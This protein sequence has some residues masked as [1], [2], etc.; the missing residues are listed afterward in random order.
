MDCGLWVSGGGLL[1]C[2]LLWYD[3]CY[4]VVVCLLCIREEKDEEKEREK[5]RDDDAQYDESF[6]VIFILFYCI[7]R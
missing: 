7:K 2:G 3:C 4:G 6:I 5:D 1:I